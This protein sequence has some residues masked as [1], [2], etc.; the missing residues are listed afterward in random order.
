MLHTFDIGKLLVI[1]TEVEEKMLSVDPSMNVS[2]ALGDYGFLY[3]W[4]K[5]AI[6]AI[7]FGSL[8]YEVI[9]TVTG[10]SSNY[11]TLFLK[12]IFLLTLYNYSGPLI[13]FVVGDII[14][15]SSAAK[16]RIDVS[17]ALTDFLDVMD[18]ASWNAAQDVENHI[19]GKGKP[20]SDNN[21]APKSSDKAPDNEDAPWYMK[22][23]GSLNS[24]LNAL[25]FRFLA[26]IL[27][28][29]VLIFIGLA[30]LTK[31]IM[32]DIVWPVMY[33]LTLI[34]F[35]F[36]FVFASLPGGGVAI[37][38]FATSL[39]EIALWPIIYGLAF[40]AVENNFII[41][42]KKITDQMTS[43]TY[44]ATI[45]DQVVVL[46]QN[47]ITGNFILILQVIGY[48]VFLAV[49]AFFVPKIASMIVRS[50]SA[51]AVGAMA[52][53]AVGKGLSKAGTAMALAGGAVGGQMA[54]G[55]LNAG[56]GMMARAQNT[57]SSLGEMGSSI[58][59]SLPGTAPGAG[60]YSAAGK[61]AGAASQ[62]MSSA[63]D[64]A[65]SVSN[66]SQDAL[67]RGMGMRNIGDKGSSSGNSKSSGISGKSSENS[68]SANTSHSKSKA[69][70]S[71]GSGES[72]KGGKSG[73]R[74]Q[75]GLNASES[76]SY[77]NA[78]SKASPEQA[79][80]MRNLYRAMNNTK[81]HGPEKVQ[82]YKNQLLNK[83]NEI[84]NNK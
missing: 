54:A 41:S 59:Q 77:S 21:N 42:I 8:L 69:S 12:F 49:I 53:M 56:S 84:N 33:Q 9:R 57:L 83:A 13:N 74:N 36:S 61:A 58:N 51:A 80:E 17:K 47:L 37:R 52:G 29:V 44:K 81:Q 75:K 34:G 65:Q 27:F 24:F 63:A 10:Q 16:S 22:I 11:F 38:K 2:A 71:S 82:E 4:G 70:A 48:C 40:N 6:I 55:M 67:L 50:E 3:I 20:S 78:I 15:Q 30:L 35:V 1:K 25:Y 19:K 66:M 32:L 14:G 73:V 31:F 18:N 60:A 72:S 64:A 79:K 45:G 26:G 23:T 68:G 7:F 5:Y 62:G 76:N 28:T 43:D 46:V 39:I